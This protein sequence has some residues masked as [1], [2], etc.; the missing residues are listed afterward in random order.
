MGILIVGRCWTL[1]CC[2]EQKDCQIGS[3]MTLYQHFHC[4][5]APLLT[6]VSTTVVKI[7]CFLILIY[8]IYISTL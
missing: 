2:P 5:R 6:A 3:Q 4:S 1:P 7:I 8:F